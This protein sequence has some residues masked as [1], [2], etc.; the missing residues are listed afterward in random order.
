MGNPAGSDGTGASVCRG[1]EDRHPV[2]CAKHPAGCNCLCVRGSSVSQATMTR[3][4]VRSIPPKFEFSKSLPLAA[5]KDAPL[6]AHNVWFLICNPATFGPTLTG[7]LDHCA[8]VGSEGNGGGGDD[9]GVVS[10]SYCVCHVP[11]YL[12]KKMHPHKKKKKKKKNPKK[13]KK[14][15]KKK[16]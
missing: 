12:P 3:F 8:S 13:K 7:V 15:K 2:G 9:V 6:P 1:A 14:K 16:S 11:S 10:A 5:C 4:P